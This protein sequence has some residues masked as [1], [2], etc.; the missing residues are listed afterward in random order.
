ME[1]I[2][3]VEGIQVTYD[4]EKLC[5]EVK[6]ITYERENFVNN[7]RSGDGI[8]LHEGAPTEEEF[9][10]LRNAFADEIL[11]LSETLEE[12][13]SKNLF[14]TKKNIPAKN[15]RRIILEPNNGFY[16][17]T[18]DEYDHDIQFDVPYVKLDMITNTTAKLIIHQMQIN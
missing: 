12:K 18:I 1:E 2:I 9:I 3:F 15:R 11:L 6:N 5:S 13:I 17:N 7:H 14:L 10:K 8:T 16:V 4:L